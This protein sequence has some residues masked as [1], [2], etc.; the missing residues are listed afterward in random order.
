MHWCM[1]RRD[2]TN[3]VPLRPKSVRKIVIVRLICL[4]RMLT[5]VKTYKISENF[6]SSCATSSKS[7]E[8][9]PT[10]RTLATSKPARRG[11]AAA[12]DQQRRLLAAAGVEKG[13]NYCPANLP[14][15]RERVRGDLTSICDLRLLENEHISCRIFWWPSL[16][17]FLSVASDPLPPHTR[18]PT[19]TPRRY[20]Q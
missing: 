16:L 5:S 11:A 2:S 17:P 18:A 20:K 10:E 3:R 12:P 6:I 9:E 19:R 8:M 13:L 14:G 15:E 1:V 7:K 4:N